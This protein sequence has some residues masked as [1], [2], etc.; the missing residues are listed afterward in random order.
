MYKFNGYDCEIHMFFMMD[1]V[2]ASI[3]DEAS[4]ITE[5]K[6]ENSFFQPTTANI[7]TKRGQL[8]IM[9]YKSQYLSITKKTLRDVIFYRPRPMN[10]DAILQEKYEDNTET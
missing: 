6:L 2:V 8:A 3:I 7:L 10:K 5:S 4:P 1:Y 9:I